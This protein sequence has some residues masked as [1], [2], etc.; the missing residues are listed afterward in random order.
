MPMRFGA[1]RTRQARRESPVM[2]Q[3]SLEGASRRRHC[4][5]PEPLVAGIRQSDSPPQCLVALTP[6]C[7][8]SGNRLAPEVNGRGEAIFPQTVKIRV[9]LRHSAPLAALPQRTIDQ[10]ACQR[11]LA[12]LAHLCRSARRAA[13]GARG[14]VGGTLGARSTGRHA[15]RVNDRFRCR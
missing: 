15:I 11:S 9:K 3:E 13:G 6:Q 12:T 5:P 10:V 4:C 14:V 2:T 1:L 7:A 8:P